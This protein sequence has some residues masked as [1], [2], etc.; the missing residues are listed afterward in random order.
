[1]S[2]ID[3]LICNNPYYPPSL[4]WENT[5]LHQYTRLEGRRKAGYTI[6][7]KEL[8]KLG[9]GTF[10]ELAFV[11][12]LRERVEQWRKAGYPFTTATTKRLL[13]HWTQRDQRGDTTQFFFC[14]IEAIETL[15][16]LTETPEGTQYRD[17][18]PS[19]GGTWQRL[20]CKMATGTGKT[21][22]MAMTI[23]WHVLNKVNDPKNVKFS[24]NVFI[25]APNLTV[26]DRLQ[27]LHP[28]AKAGEGDW[29]ETNYYEAHN[30]VPSEMMPRLRQGKILIENWH[31]LA[32]DSEVQI[33]KRKSVDKRGAKSDRAYAREVL[34]DMATAKNI[35]VLNDEAHH[36][37]RVPA[38]SKLKGI[39]KEDIR[40]AT[41]WVGGLDRLHKTCGI[42]RGYDFTATP[43]SPSGKQSD[44]AAVFSWIVSD[45]GLNDAIESGLV[46][47]P[48]V[49]IRS[50]G[51]LTKVKDE[52]QSKLYHIYE[53]EDVKTSL[54][55]K[56][57]IPEMGLPTLVKNAYVLLNAD[58]QHVAESWA[59]ESPNILPCLIT[60][61]NSTETASRVRY[62]FEKRGLHGTIDE[63]KDL[64]LYDADRILQIDSK[65]LETAESQR[66]AIQVKDD[67]KLSK[68]ELAERLR[69]TVNS[70]GRSGQLGERICNVIGVSMLS[71]GWDAKTVT[72]IMG[73]RAFTS[74]LLC[75]QVI[76]R[77]L[78]RVAYTFE[79][80]D[81]PLSNDNFLQPEYVN[82]FG[83]P[84]SIIPQEDGGGTPPPPR[85]R[86]HEIK[87]MPEKVAH[88]I[89]LPNILRVENI[90]RPILTLDKKAVT[91]LE[92][93]PYRF[94]TEAEL[95][96]V[97]EGKGAAKDI[98]NIDLKA[99]TETRLQSV[100][101][102]VAQRLF[103]QEHKKQN[104]RGREPFLFVQ[105]LKIVQDFLA[106]D[107]VRLKQDLFSNDA[108]RRTI[109]FMLAMSDIVGHILAHVREQ[110][111]EKIEVITDRERPIISTADMPSWWT[112]RPAPEARKSHLNACP[113]DSLWEASGNYFFDSCDLI[114]SWIKND[115]FGFVIW[116]FYEGQPRRYY[117]D[118]VL[119]LTNGSYVVVETKGDN[120]VLAQ[121]K[122][123]ALQGWVKAVNSLGNWGNWH[124]V[125][126]THP[127]DLEGKLKG[128]Y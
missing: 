11:N 94:I 1:M 115:H 50:D 83:V 45:F 97:V 64:P 29:K 107:K 32:W 24:K 13:S 109:V 99:S 15:I 126:S 52:V 8:T 38:G 77:G 123:K 18:L 81:D 2:K 119:R 57:A 110:N 108:E 68:D 55:Y 27:V 73:L 53:D 112:S 80:S 5:G 4:H 84:F 114:D 6:A 19:D 85:P 25:V 71:E 116:Y 102:A 120:N 82:I 12:P 46:K 26:K 48:R 40:D 113:I 62:E 22:V 104:W 3:K 16:Y 54:N 91:D 127:L 74:Q 42:L 47:T 88:Q 70:V 106:A 124:E 69:D 14:Q 79:R 28:S 61:A 60:I 56:G 10:K 31:T 41:I 23:A 122:R 9:L 121:V 100:V 86:G 118:F 39:K 43:F 63:M 35:I 34:G 125:L 96:A 7:T 30:I 105:F 21:L 95:G 101:F 67:H 36:S 17:K 111:A 44:E 75:E 66:E 49:V 93:D 87:I 90:L 78:R 72:H 51:Q 76:G 59:K 103:E 117:P 33:A 58:W 89:D 37:W 20:C 92:I 128:F 98:A 65:A